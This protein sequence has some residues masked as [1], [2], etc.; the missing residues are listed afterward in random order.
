M[1]SA[2][3]NAAVGVSISHAEQSRM[4]TWIHV[5]MWALHTYGH[6]LGIIQSVLKFKFKFAAVVVC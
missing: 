5:T 4:V 1:A 3:V 2:S 6:T